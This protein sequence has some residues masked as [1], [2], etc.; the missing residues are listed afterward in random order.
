MERDF[1]IFRTGPNEARSK[2]THVT[3]GGYGII[4]MNRNVYH[5][6]GRP[7][8]VRLA[9][10]RERDAIWVE[11]VSPRLDEAFP[12]ITDRMA[13]R[14]NAAPFCRHYNIQPDTTLKFV[15]PDINGQTMM[16]KLRETISVARP[17]RKGLKKG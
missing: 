12:V 4:R 9:Y 10:S 16:L 7:A 14:I 2:R 8:A 13:W 1:E 15:A 11:A 17:K 6:L 5:M 3:I